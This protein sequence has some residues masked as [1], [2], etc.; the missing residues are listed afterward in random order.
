M[1][2]GQRKWWPE[3]GLLWLG[4]ALRF[5]NLLALPLFADED[6]VIHV[7]RLFVFGNRLEG[8][9]HNRIVT[10]TLLAL[11][12]ALGVEAAWLGRALSALVGMLGLAAVYWLAVWLAGG[13]TGSG[14]VAGRVALFLA[15][16]MP[17][18]LFYDRQLLVDGPMAALGL[19]AVVLAIRM[20]QRDSWALALAT[21]VV[22]ALT[23]LTK[24]SGGLFV[25][26]PVGVALLLPST[27]AARRGALT[28]G[29]VAAGLAVVPLVALLGYS[30]L[31]GDGGLA[32]SKWCYLPGCE[33][34]DS[35][36]STLS[37]ALNNL[38][39][40]PTIITS[41][42]GWPVFVAALAGV[43]VAWRRGWRRAL[44]TGAVFAGLTLFYLA[45]SKILPSRYLAGTYAGMA[46]FAG[47]AVAWL[48]EQIGARFPATE[49]GRPVPHTSGVLA[50]VLAV[51]LI[52]PIAPQ[53]CRVVRDPTA[54]RFN[55]RDRADFGPGWPGAIAGARLID[56]LVAE[57]AAD[58][59]PA[60]LVYTGK[61]GLTVFT[62]W[63]PRHGDLEALGTPDELRPRLV[64]WLASAAP[65]YLQT[66]P[67]A[68]PLDP[69]THGLVVAHVASFALPN[70]ESYGW[71]YT[72]GSTAELWRVTGTTGAL[73]RAL[74]L[75]VF[76]DPATYA[77]DFAA[78][79][80]YLS[81]HPDLPVLVYPAHQLDVIPPPHDAYTVIGN[82]WPWDWPAIEAVLTET[83]GAHDQIATLF[84]IETL[85][86]KEREIERWLNAHLYPLETTW[87]GPARLVHYRTETGAV[88]APLPV[89]AQFGQLATLDTVH[90]L[91][92]TARPGDTIRL[93]L[94]WTAL[95]ATE[96]DYRVFI[97]IIAGDGS[98]VAQRD[99]IPQNGL[100]PT[101]SWSPGQAIPDRLTVSLPPE[102]P[103]GAYRVLVGVY[104]PASGARL[105]IVQE[106]A[107][108]G[109]SLPVATLTVTD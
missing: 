37:F 85:G 93:A 24:F 22:L 11:V 61:T 33:A 23:M 30:E 29:L 83:A 36:G 21:A 86:D 79:P 95:S 67:P 59:A 77:A 97:H 43:A 5:H 35:A 57:T 8:L 7:A 100:T 102:L 25:A 14:A 64:Q 15:A 52:L 88:G 71:L 94:D 44:V 47:A 34:D 56:T 41:L 10:S 20:V 91:D 60:N 58:S 82:S 105:A 109:D 54:I 16:V 27:R 90:L 6:T 1:S 108:V 81:A 80:G 18:V 19:L 26:A 89:A 70:H 38:Q 32:I 76:G 74:N 73:S 53:T 103:A 106:S 51:A 101:L 42:V 12:G 65:V 13:R 49:A 28:K 84:W 2:A 3:A 72:E 99:G 4:A 98:L 50:A 78:L 55:P 40:Y 62:L 92:P 9:V 46:V 68:Y 107:A 96:I 87:F 104:D 31:S 75:A 63:G 66:E 45:L 39:I 69:D 17:A 48:A